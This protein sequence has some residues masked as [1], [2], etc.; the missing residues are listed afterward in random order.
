[1]CST[2]TPEINARTHNGATRDSGLR[3]QPGRGA[4]E[5][6]AAGA[7]PQHGMTSGRNRRRSHNL[8]IFE[9]IPDSLIVV[10]AASAIEDERIRQ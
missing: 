9:P 10:R 1:M 3:G 5:S 4:E 2:N 8:P 6:H 7:E